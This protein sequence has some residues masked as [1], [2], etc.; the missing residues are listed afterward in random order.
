MADPS[1]SMVEASNRQVGRIHTQEE[2]RGREDATRG[3][4][5]SPRASS[6]TLFVDFQQ[7]VG[8]CQCTKVY[9][10]GVTTYL[11]VHY[12]SGH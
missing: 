11:P 10:H 4:A 3:T 5:D 6:S 1:T 9:N 7:A 8:R 12:N 2:A